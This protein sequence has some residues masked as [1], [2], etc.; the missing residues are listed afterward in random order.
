MNSNKKPRCTK[1]TFR[2]KEKLSV[3]WPVEP[4]NQFRHQKKTTLVCKTLNQSRRG[5]FYWQLTRGYLI[6]L[7]CKNHVYLRFRRPVV[8]SMGVKRT[9]IFQPRMIFF[10]AIFA[11]WELET[12]KNLYYWKIKERAKNKHEKCDTTLSKNKDIED[13]QASMDSL[14]SRRDMIIYISHNLALTNISLGDL[15]LL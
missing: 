15:R 11:L 10:F 12:M 2:K 13:W 5:I 1:R 8:A 6:Q 4:D 7:D 9:A 14:Q 3:V